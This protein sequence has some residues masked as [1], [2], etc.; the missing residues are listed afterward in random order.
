MIN[1]LLHV[2]VGRRTADFI[3]DCTGS[4]RRRNGHFGIRFYSM[5]ALGRTPCLLPTAPPSIQIRSG[6]AILVALELFGTMM[7]PGVG[8]ST[9]G[10]KCNMVESESNVLN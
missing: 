3:Q 9:V 5:T 8:R 4:A 6:A 2:H 7:I 1:I 10:V